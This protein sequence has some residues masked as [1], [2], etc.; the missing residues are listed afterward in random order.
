MS[1][2]THV[3]GVFDFLAA[4]GSPFE[5][6]EVEA[7]G[8]TYTGYKNAPP[9]VRQLWLAIKADDSDDYLV[10]EDE[11]MTWAGGQSKWRVRWPSR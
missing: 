7:R 5:T 1:A 8:Q 6:C 10:Y 3:H 4:P 11:R 9:Q 2:V